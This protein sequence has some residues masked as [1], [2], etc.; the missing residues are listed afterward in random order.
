MFA[1]SHSARRAVHH[2][3]HLLGAHQE[4]VVTVFT[5][6]LGD[7]RAVVGAVHSSGDVDEVQVRDHRAVRRVLAVDVL[8]RRGAADHVHANQRADGVGVLEPTA[9]GDRVGGRGG[10]LG[11]RRV[12]GVRLRVGRGVGVH[13]AVDDGRD[14]ALGRG[15]PARRFRAAPHEERGAH[16]DGQPG[17][18]HG[19]YSLSPLRGTGIR[20]ALPFGRAENSNCSKKA[21]VESRDVS[22]GEH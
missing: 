15:R 14:V 18:A 12:G 4:V 17:V 3:L 16:D 9:R 5:H 6:L 1:V 2:H 11:D 22:A 8:R 20:G 19:A 21:Q 13:V 10:V 7:A